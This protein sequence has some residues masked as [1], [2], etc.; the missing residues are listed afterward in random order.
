[1]KKKWLSLLLVGVMALSVAL[2]GCGGS[3]GSGGSGGG[4]SDETGAAPAGG[5]EDAAAA[6]D[7]HLDFG[8]YWFGDD[9]DPGNGWNGW[10]LTRAA[11]GETLVTVDENLNFVGQIADEWSVDD[12]QV[13]WRFHIRDGVTFQNGNVCDAE[14][15]V[16]SI[17]RSLEVNERGQTN[18]KLASVEAD[19]DWV[20][21][22]TE[23]P[24][25]AFLAN[26]TE[27]LFVIVDTSVDTS[28]Y[29]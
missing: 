18:L 20:V 29:G 14:A 12:D 22:T 3:G 11:V 16:G 26:L 1:M 4:A 25:G 19:G 24:Y 28:D 27:P 13:T 17:Q 6:E 2:S 7:S 9:L 15:V 5:G 10:T 8:I 21:F 23:E